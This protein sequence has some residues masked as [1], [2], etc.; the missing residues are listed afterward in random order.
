MHYPNIIDYCNCR[1]RSRNEEQKI[2]VDWSIIPADG[3][4]D[5]GRRRLDHGA[6]SRNRADQTTGS[7]PNPLADQDCQAYQN[8]TTITDN[9]LNKNPPADKNALAGYPYAHLYTHKNPERSP[10]DPNR[11]PNKETLVV[12]VVN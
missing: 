4:Y 8:R 3:D 6:S 2:C 12:V 10:E 9:G 7:Q 11:Y 1:L 5:S